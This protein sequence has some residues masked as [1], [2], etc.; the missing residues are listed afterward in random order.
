MEQAGRDDS[1]AAELV[2]EWLREAFLRVGMTPL[3]PQDK[4]RW[5]QRLIAITNTAKRD[6]PRALEQQRRFDDDW[7]ARDET[8][9]SEPAA[10]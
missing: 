1:A 3:P 4:G 2:S 5:H 9:D 8:S 10:D 6:T 7:R